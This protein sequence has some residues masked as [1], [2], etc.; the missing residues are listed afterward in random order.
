M[1]RNGEVPQEL[2]R[3]LKDLARRRDEQYAFTIRRIVLTNWANGRV[4]S[5]LD[6]ETVSGFDAYVE[7]VAKGYDEWH[8]YV[9]K[10]Q[11]V[12]DHDL[13]QVLYDQLRAWAY[14][15]ARGTLAAVS[16]S[17]Q[18]LHAENCASDAG[19]EL[20][21]SHFPY[22]TAFNPWAYVVL[23]N[24]CRGYLNR[25]FNPRSIPDHEVINLQQWEGWLQNLSDPS[26]QDP[27]EQF[28]LG[29]LLAQA[30]EQLP[31][32]QQE[33]VLLYYSD[34]KDYEE[35]SQLTGRSLDALYKARFDSLRS[36]R[37]ILGE[38]LNIH[39]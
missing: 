8:E 23:R 19:V 3:A 24:V 22:D 34:Q 4:Q 33:F 31:P 26:S 16:R 5:F 25:L 6:S 12:R 29:Q 9:Y 7:H 10:I 18:R 21:N 35:I 13:W 37:K 28:E 39:E 1:N 36:L 32:G 27:F 30:I 38:M 17:E 15:L 20:V 2:E 14:G 11:T